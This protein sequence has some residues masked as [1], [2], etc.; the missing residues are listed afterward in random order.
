MR[1]ISAQAITLTLALLLGIFAA[2]TGVAATGKAAPKSAD[3]VDVNHAT[4]EVLETLPGIQEAYALK[5]VR[6][7]P[8]ANKTQLSSK[9]VL[10]AATYRRIRALVI[11]KQ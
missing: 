3:L 1:R 5:I 8:Y 7:R 6:N 9:G 10:P 11:A 2:V 4:V